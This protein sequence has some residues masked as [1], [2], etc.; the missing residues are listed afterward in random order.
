MVTDFLLEFS[1]LFLFSSS[2]QSLRYS[3]HSGLIC[4]TFICV[5]LPVVWVSDRNERCRHQSQIKHATDLQQSVISIHLIPLTQ[6][7]SHINTIYV[8]LCVCVYVKPEILFKRSSLSSP[9]VENDCYLIFMWRRG[10]ALIAEMF[11]Q[12]QTRNS[13]SVTSRVQNIS[14]GYDI[15]R[16]I[17]APMEQE[18][19]RPTLEHAFSVTIITS[20]HAS[21]T[22]KLCL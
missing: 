20:H 9:E 21:H 11:K 7:G 2:L 17:T 13:I 19:D 3:Y 16:Q 14:P 18:M 4:L 15:C 12:Q 1:F 8:P 10:W 22:P 6:W 5:V